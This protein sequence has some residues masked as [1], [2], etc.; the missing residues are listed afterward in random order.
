MQNLC[1][2]LLTFSVQNFIILIGGDTTMT[3]RTRRTV[4][5]PPQCI[6]ELKKEAETLGISVNA[7]INIIIDRHLSKK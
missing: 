7:L 1:K 4:R 3:P 6:E 5:I 2:I